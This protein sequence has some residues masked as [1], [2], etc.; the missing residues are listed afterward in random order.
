MADEKSNQNSSQDADEAL[1]Q[2]VD[3]EGANDA[4]KGG[5]EQGLGIGQQDSPVWTILP[6]RQLAECLEIQHLVTHR[7]QSA[8]S[9]TL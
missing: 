9:S 1:Q 3:F 8:G 7:P 6:Q 4:Q 5:D 2:L